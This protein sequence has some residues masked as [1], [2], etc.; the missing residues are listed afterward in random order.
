MRSDA[1]RADVGG[2]RLHHPGRYS[3]LLQVPRLRDRDPA[4][5]HDLEVVMKTPARPVPRRE[6]G[7]ILFIALIVLVAMSLAGIAL[8]RSVDTNV[9]IAG[10]LAF[11]Q[12]ATSAGDWGI[13]SAR[14]WMTGN[15]AV[16]EKDQPDGAPFYFANWQE[17]LDRLRI[18][19][20]TK[21]YDWETPEPLDLGF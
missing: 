10:N 15:L 2:R 5:Q 13:E 20:T 19:P 6:R 8:M 7:A 21:A 4:A 3:E 16:L 9:L 1:S 14:I 18:H 17:K 12:G 11:R